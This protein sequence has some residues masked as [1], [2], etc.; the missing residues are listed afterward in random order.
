MMIRRTLL[1]I[2]LA[3][4]V[5]AGP[6]RAE[7]KSLVVAGGCFW[8]VE[9]D[10]DKVAGVVGTT[11][12]YAGGTMENPTY[13]NHSGHREVVKID[14]DS[15]VTDYATLVATFLRTIDPTDGDGQFCDRGH[16]YTPAIHAATPEELA[17]A[18]AAVA[19]AQLTIGGPLAIP[20]EGAVRFWEAEDY[21]QNYWQSQEKQLTR[22]GLVTR[23][24]AYKGYREGCGRDRRVRQVWGDEAYKGVDKAGH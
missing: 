22:F 5:I 19:D 10:F 9:S 6:A 20:V 17:A 16:S 15:T 2:C 23:A 21:H 11:S 7:V 1:A 24:E 12:G 14:Y 8:C 18:M 13:R 4:G 3:A